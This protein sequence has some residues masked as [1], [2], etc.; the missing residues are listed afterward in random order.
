[1]THSAHPRKGHATSRLSMELYAH[2]PDAADRQ[3][4]A[5]LEDQWAKASGTG[6]GDRARSGHAD[7]AE[8]ALRPQTSWSERVEVMGLEPTTSTLRT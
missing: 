4:A 8:Q 2:V 3:V 1:M 6:Q 7:L 5:H